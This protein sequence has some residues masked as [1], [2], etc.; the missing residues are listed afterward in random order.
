[1]SKNI[2]A[3]FYFL[4]KLFSM[5][6]EGRK[7]KLVKYNKE[8]QKDLDITLT[9]YKFFSGRY[10]IYESKGK[11]KEFDGYDNDRLLFEG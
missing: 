4:N 6:E 3:S 5:I 11:G 1:M 8:I 7:L 2:K 10:I 9:N